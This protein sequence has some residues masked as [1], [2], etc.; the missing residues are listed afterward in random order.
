MGKIEGRSR[1][2]RAATLTCNHNWVAVTEDFQAYIWT[3]TECQEEDGGG[4]L[5]EMDVHPL[6]PEIL[7]PKGLK[8]PDWI[9]TRWEYQ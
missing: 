5:K 8:I 4:Q 1:E 2:G 6:L 3:C 9:A 7:F